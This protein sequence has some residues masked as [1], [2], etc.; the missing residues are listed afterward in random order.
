MGGICMEKKAHKGTENLIPMNKL[1][2]EAQR[3][4]A[5]KGGKAS[6]EKRKKNKTF[7][8]ALEWYLALEVKATD[9][10]EEKLLEQF[11][12]LTYRDYV[13][14]SATEAA[15]KD[16]DVRAMVFARDTM[17]ETPATK[18]EVGQEK[19]FEINIKTLD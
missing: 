1:S 7:K 11:P 17:G 19:P 12:G 8:E 5:S 2:K 15:S 6:V 13:A 10:T 4:I 9:K 16:K 14:I 3:E 18:L